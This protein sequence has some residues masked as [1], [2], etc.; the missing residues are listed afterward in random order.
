V[1]LRSRLVLIL[2][3]RTGPCSLLVPIKIY[4]P[5]SALTTELIDKVRRLK[6]L[7]PLVI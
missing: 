2:V 3:S 7:V 4:V 5:S 6:L 1:C